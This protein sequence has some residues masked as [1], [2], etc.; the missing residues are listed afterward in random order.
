MDF[1]KYKT[2]LTSQLTAVNAEIVEK[3]EELGKLKDFRIR[4]KGGLEVITQIESDISN[5]NQT[6]T[7]TP[8]QLQQEIRETIEDLS[9]K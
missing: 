1:Q 4:V 8:I 3:E 7:S 6:P 2:N 5:S 9:H